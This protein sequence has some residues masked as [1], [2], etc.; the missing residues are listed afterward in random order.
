MEDSE[1]VYRPR[2]PSR[3]KPRLPSIGLRV[4]FD[5]EVLRNTLQERLTLDNISLSQ[6]AISI[7]VNKAT[8][9][10]FMNMLREPDVQTAT[11]VVCW[12]ELSLDKFIRQE[13]RD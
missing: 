12:L 6:A 10:R 7:G 4:W 1:R 5:T 2:R 8:L 13:F 11:R 3:L 9:S